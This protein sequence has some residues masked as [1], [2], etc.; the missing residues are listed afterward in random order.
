MEE[1]INLY[2]SNVYEADPVSIKLNVEFTEF[3]I[4]QSDREYLATLES[5]KEMGQHDPILMLNGECVDG[6]H[7]IKICSELGISVKCVDLNPD[8]SRQQILDL[9]NKSVM[10]GRDYTLTQRTILAYDYTKR[11][12]CLV[13]DAA[14]KWKVSKSDMS[15]VSTIIKLGQYGKYNGV[16]VINA[17]REG[18][19]IQLPSMK[20]P[21]KSIQV[22]YRH[23]KEQQMLVVKK[24]DS[25]ESQS[26]EIQQ[27]KPTFNFV[28]QKA[29]NKYVEFML[30]HDVG[31]NEST[32]RE[33]MVDVMNR[34]YPQ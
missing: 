1:S 30:A 19:A 20:E 8:L 27:Q 15:Y 31:E 18:D 23:I 10:T 26:N 11:V 25:H 7:R 21:S 22:I 14:V 5:I 29:K 16:D 4:M 24:K 12:G 3:N 34:S 32:L 13:K 9:A 6:R 17:L 33:L 28:S 2:A